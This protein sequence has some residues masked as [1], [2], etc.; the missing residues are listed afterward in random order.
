MGIGV[1]YLSQFFLCHDIKN[2]QMKLK[3]LATIRSG[4]VLARKESKQKT[5]H[6]YTLLNL[7]SIHPGG[8]IGMKTLDVFWA[9]EI[10]DDAYLSQIGDVI[11]R[12]SVPYTA[13]CIDKSTR[14]LV[15]PSNFVTIRTNNDRLLPEFLFWFL[16]RAQ[17]RRL[18][19]ENSGGNMMAAIKPSYFADLEL[20]DID[21]RK[22]KRIAEIHNTARKEIKLLH[23]LAEAKEQY[24]AGILDRLIE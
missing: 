16:N 7:R 9:T 23:D 10:L 6:Q 4:L 21:L 17:T 11:V 3:D 20:P 14:N 13:V 18:F 2:V 22:Q 15:I 19:Y 8:H 5:T 24:Y 12:L 1:R